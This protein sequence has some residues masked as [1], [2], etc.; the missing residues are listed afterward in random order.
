MTRD[1][2]IVGGGLHGCSAA[3]HLASRGVG[4]IVLEKE[5]VGRHASGASA[6]G[7]RRL[8]RHVA[9]IPLSVVAMEM[10]W[11][12]HEWLGDDC[13]FKE[14]GQIRVAETAAAMGM[15]EA[16]ARRVEDLGYSHEELV[17]RGEMRRLVPAISPA[18]IGGLVSRRDGFADPYRTTS[19]FCRQAKSL[20]VRVIVGAGV[21]SVERAGEL[22]R[23]VTPKGPFEASAI[24]NCAGAWGDRLA[25]M[26][27][28]R[29]VPVTVGPSMMTVT[30][31]MAHFVDPVVI[32]TTRN[33]SFKQSHNGTVLIGGGHWARFNPETETTDLDFDK[34][35]IGARTVVDT[36]PIMGQ[37]R[38]N[39][40]WAG[41][42]GRLPDDIPVIG[43]S[44][45]LPGVFHGFSFCGHGFQLGPVVGRIIA[46]LV[47]D[48]RTD[49]P[50]EP[51]HIDRFAD[52]SP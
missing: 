40:C 46:D 45:K 42:E 31:P 49:L 37:A 19:A 17:D 7:V 41:L 2:I 18:M 43:A 51:F 52:P 30:Y 27:G 14:G 15:L 12:I 11:R 25:A 26:L 8:G 21:Q 6:G 5:T 50:I 36:F 38:I 1:A 48:G 44:A 13:G 33:L 39:R 32:H 10:W 24:V 28:E 35:A 3:Y 47:V 4:C 22:W 9:E 23:V 20:G 16:R 34:L 29:Q